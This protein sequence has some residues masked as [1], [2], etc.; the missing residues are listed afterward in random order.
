MSELFKLNGT[1]TLTGEKNTRRTYTYIYIYMNTLHQQTH[2]V[3]AHS[4]ARPSIIYY[5]IYVYMLWV[6]DVYT[7]GVHTAHKTII[8]YVWNRPSVLT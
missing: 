5:I 4:Q 3:H 2:C 7:T 6:Y 8:G 1:P